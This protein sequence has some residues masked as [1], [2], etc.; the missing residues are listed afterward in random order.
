M[1]F[2]KNYRRHLCDMHINDCND[3]YLSKFSPEDYFAKLKLANIQNAMIYFQSHVGLCYY[4]TKIGKIHNAFIGREEAIRSLVNMCRA[5]KIAVTGYYSLIFNNWARDNH[6]DWRIVSLNEEDDLGLDF[7]SNYG[8][9][10]TCCPNNPQ[11]R[12]F[13]LGQIDEMLE[14][15]EVDGM[16]FDMPLW[17]ELCK[18]KHC[19]ARF[20]KET[21][22][23]MPV[24][25]NWADPV[26]RLHI[27]KRREWMGNF[28]S[29]VTNQVKLHGNDISVEFNVASAALTRV[30]SGLAEEVVTKSDYAGCDL[31]VNQ[32]KQSFACKL[33]KNLTRNQPFEYMISRCEPSLQKHTVSRSVDTLLSQTFLTAAH[34]GATLFIDALDPVGTMDE[35]VY[36]RFGYVFKKEAQYERFFSG[37]M[38]ED[39]GIY[40]SLRSKF[41]AHGEVWTNY[42]STVNIVENLVKNNVLCGVTGSCA[43]IYKY[44]LLIAP[45]LTEDD[46]DDYERLIDYVNN[47]GTLYISGGDCYELLETFFNAKITGRTNE[48][49]V[50]IAPC[51]CKLEKAF[52]WFNKEYPLHFDGSAPITEGISNENVLAYI[53]LPY[54]VQGT[55]EFAS[56][57]SDP[58]GKETKIPAMAITQFGKGKVF[59][60]ALSVE[61]VRDSYHYGKIF[62]N[63]LNDILSAPCT[64]KSNAPED[65]EIVVFAEDDCMTVSSVKYCSGETAQKTV[66]FYI[67]IS[68]CRIPKKIL[69]LPCEIECAFEYNDDTFRYE[70]NELNIVDMRKILF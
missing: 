40:Y 21:G 69:Q 31:Y 25:E 53:T 5:D 48:S 27:K 49:V 14:Y 3:E 63:I 18:C 61:A 8:R 33:F 7:T 19:R 35:R 50:Y 29:D 57:H 37:E 23:D 64:L 17:P 41:N 52:G 62:I 70:V 68:S 65:V 24:S 67:E 38:V 44:K 1:W 15:F 13:V 54:T 51:D 47:G 56:I 16:F 30:T 28:A 46:I 2:E 45:G 34:H 42:N 39:V 58:P 60:S 12:S 59:W 26:W 6:P 55:E 4:P 43:D 11:Y 22:Y 36:E 32:Y 20:R 10:G 9:Y 66:P